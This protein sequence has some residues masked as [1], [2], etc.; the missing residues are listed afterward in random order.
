MPFIQGHANKV[1]STS[2]YRDGS[3]S[4]LAWPWN[5]TRADGVLLYAERNGAAR[6][7]VPRTSPSRCK[8]LH[9]TACRAHLGVTV[10]LPPALLP[11][12]L[13]S[14]CSYAVCSSECCSVR[15]TGPPDSVVASGACSRSAE[16]DERPMK[17]TAIHRCTQVHDDAYTQ[18]MKD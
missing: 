9:L 18:V 5:S 8:G 12:P 6:A 13:S 7:G 16:A 14:R 1:G 11:S 17:V 15:I 2:R 10:A 3:F 4:W